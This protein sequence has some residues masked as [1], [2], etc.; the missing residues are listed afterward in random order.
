MAMVLNLDL[1]QFPAQLVAD[2]DRLD[3]VRVF[4]QFNKH[5]QIVVGLVNK[6]LHL[7]ENV[8]VLAKNR[9]EKKYPLIYQK[10]S[11]TVLEL[12]YQAKEKLV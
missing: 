6:F 3:L 1:N 11:M 9:L 7:V 5:A 10:V 2:T 8:K 12:D 4:L